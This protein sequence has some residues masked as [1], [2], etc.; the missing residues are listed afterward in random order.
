[1]AIDYQRLLAW[2]VPEIRQTYS[3]R[4]SQLY[5]LAVGLGADPT[6]TRQLPFVYEQPRRRCPR[7][8]W[9]WATPVSG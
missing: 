6:D 5:A 4:D 9:C 7:R 3:V 2:P 1:M 8:R